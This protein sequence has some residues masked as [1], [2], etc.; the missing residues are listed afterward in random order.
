[1]NCML[2]F[3]YGIFNAPD[4]TSLAGGSFGRQPNVLTGQTECSILLLPLSL[5]ERLAQVTALEGS[6][7]V[8]V[9]L[10]GAAR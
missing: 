8:G 1:M 10:E 7:P 6:T 2:N 3:T 4:A 9:G 5:P